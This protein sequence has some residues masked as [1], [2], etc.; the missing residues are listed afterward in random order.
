MKFFAYTG[1]VYN[2]DSIE[3]V[4][5]AGFEAAFAV[6]PKLLGVDPLFEMP[7]MDIYASSMIKFKIKTKRFHNSAKKLMIGM[8]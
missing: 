7:R 8:K 1:G 3:V 2:A 5:L 6:R 4:K